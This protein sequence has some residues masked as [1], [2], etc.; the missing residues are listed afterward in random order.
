MYIVYVCT[1]WSLIKK[2]VAKAH[3]N[4]QSINTKD[5]ALP[6]YLPRDIPMMLMHPNTPLTTPMTTPV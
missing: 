1:A 5:R 3:A 2:N 4:S 6:H